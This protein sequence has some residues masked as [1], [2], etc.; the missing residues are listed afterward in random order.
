MGPQA[1]CGRLRLTRKISNGHMRV[2][3]VTMS[4]RR[5][6]GLAVGATL[7]ILT[8]TSAASQTG[9][10]ISGTYCLSG[11]REVGSCFRFTADRRFEYYLSYGAYDET[12]EGL[13]QLEGS[14]VVLES[15]AYDRQPT[16]N[17]KERRAAHS[18]N[19]SVV[20]VNAGGRGLAGVDVRVR[21]DNRVVEGYT[22]QDGYT[23]SCA[24]AP[25][26]VALGIRMVGLAYRAVPLVGAGDGKALVFQFEPGDLGRKAFAGTRLRREGD[27]LGMIYRS[28]AV[29][30]LDGRPFTYRRN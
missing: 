25:S 14:D 20:V 24:A 2:R 30:D 23:T 22:Q 18:D 19:F 5:V 26:E 7:A 4:A 28:P 10:S 13:W 3:G 15:P 21:C 29:Q 8:A 6:S 16:F 9:R 27:G 17:F 1:L 12:S 11:V